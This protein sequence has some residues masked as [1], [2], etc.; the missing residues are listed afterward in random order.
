MDLFLPLSRPSDMSG[1]ERQKA[2]ALLRVLLTEAVATAN[3]PQ[4]NG[5]KGAGNE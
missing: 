1:A 2:V 3:E 4:A 5:K